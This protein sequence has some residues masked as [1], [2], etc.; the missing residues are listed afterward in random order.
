MRKSALVLF[1]L[2]ALVAS[3]PAFAKA[4]SGSYDVKGTTLDG[5]VYRGTM[6]ITARG[7]V[8]DVTWKVGE[9]Q[10]LGVGLAHGDA[11]SI[12]FT[13]GNRT[14]F[15]VVIYRQI[16]DDRLEGKWTVAGA[17]QIGTE[18]ATRK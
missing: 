4:Y 6:T 9:E 2:L 18:T 12:A 8:Y 7:D 15:G 1:A 10:Y 14:W 17:E 3:T 11:L 16:E 13:G 5:A